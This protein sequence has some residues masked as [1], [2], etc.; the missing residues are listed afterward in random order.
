MIRE[1]IAE[2]RQ[3]I[4]YAII[5]G[6]SATLDFIMFLVLYNTLQINPLVATTISTSFGILSSFIGNIL[7]N[8]KVRDKLHHR[9]IVFYIV[10]VSGLGLSVLTIYVLHDLLNLNA[11][12]AKLISIPIVVIFQYILNSRVS[13][14]KEFKLK[15][16]R[17]NLE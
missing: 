4:L 10:G 14:A 7:L 13:L 16:L 3:F 8:F 5:G 11:N 12:L 17:K 9:F 1:L 6:F 15:R 2:Q